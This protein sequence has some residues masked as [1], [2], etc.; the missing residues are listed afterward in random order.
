MK[1]KIDSGHGLINRRAIGHTPINKG[2]LKSVEIAAVAGAEV[3]EY[4]DFR[5]ALVVLGEM[6]A[7][8]AGTAGDEDAHGEAMK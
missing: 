2:V 5:R 3:V 6:A 7:D 8:E 4:D 1:H